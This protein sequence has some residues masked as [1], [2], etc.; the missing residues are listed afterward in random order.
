MDLDDDRLKGLGRMAVTAAEVEFYLRALVWELISED[1][2]VARLT[3][4]A[5]QFH[6]LL[7]LLT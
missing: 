2:E 4:G 6:R 1:T 7:A 3:F 5:P